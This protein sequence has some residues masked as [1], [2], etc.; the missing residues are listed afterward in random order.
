MRSGAWTA[1][2]I[3]CSLVPAQGQLSVTAF[4]AGWSQGWSN[5]GV[6]TADKIDYSAATN[7]IHFALF[8]RID[9]T[10]DASSNSI[11]Q[12]NSSQLISRAHAAGKKVLISVGGWNSD[13]AFRVATAPL[14]A[15]LFV[16]NLRDFIVARGYD[17]VD[18]DW[19]IL[20]QA[21]SM[22]YLSFV[23]LLRSRFLGIRP[24]P[25]ITAAA[26]WCPGII[27]AAS[28]YLDQIDIMTYDLSGPWPGWV[29][30]HN[31]PVKGGGYVFPGTSRPVPSIDALVDQFAA[32]GVPKQKITIGIDFYGYIWSGGNGT[33]TGGV[34]GPRQTW[35][36]S[37]QV[38]PNVP[39]SVIYQKYYRP[40]YYRWDAEAEAAYLSIS[41]DS[42]SGDKFISYDDENSCRHKVAYARDK[43]IAGVFIWE[44]G[45]GFLPEGYPERDRLLQS[46]KKATGGGGIRIFAAEPSGYSLRQNYPNPFNP[47]TTIDYELPVESNVILK[48]FD[49]S[50]R[51]VA[52]LVS[53]SQS[54]GNHRVQWDAGRL[55]SGAYSYR[56]ESTD[57][58][59]PARTF[60]QTKRAVFLK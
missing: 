27:A 12:E 16:N 53:G 51:Q 37:P 40:E 8:P 17:G 19:E 13:A 4:Y 15:P 28:Q 55:A 11:L 48:V 24:R 31:S 36:L 22:Q 6:L 54:A 60:T 41:A 32:A 25:L 50:G 43:G 57:V 59:N 2:L 33:S 7:I 10:L 3:C 14:F 35:T 5:N 34:T 23:S 58:T 38:Q 39:Y 56:L 29:T 20:D 52:R 1:I 44:L 46:V 30:W 21:D 18:I 49:G 47:T 45:G 42:V 26:A 9:G